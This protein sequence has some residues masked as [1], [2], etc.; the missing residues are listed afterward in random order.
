M[1]EKYL[2]KKTLYNP[3]TS[4]VVLLIVAAGLIYL[5]FKSDYLRNLL[6][7]IFGNSN[8]FVLKHF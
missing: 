2:P 4:S 6:I 1:T 3:K 5:V 7:Q 8:D